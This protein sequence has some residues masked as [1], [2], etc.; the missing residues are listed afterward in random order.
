[1]TGGGHVDIHVEI[2]QP[3]A[4]LRIE[5]QTDQT[6]LPALHDGLLAIR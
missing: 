1:M 4:N 3:R 6:F 5:A 2:N